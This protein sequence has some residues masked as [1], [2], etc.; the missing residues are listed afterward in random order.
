VIFA[1]RKMGW[2]GVDIGTSSVKLVQLMRDQDGVRIAASA[3]VARRDAWPLE[4]LA[5]CEAKSSVDE[6]GVGQSLQSGFR[7]NRV[8]A[9]LPMALSDVHVL[10]TTLDAQGDREGETDRIVRQAIETATQH[11]ADPLLCDHWTAEP[12]QDVGSPG[13]TNVLTVPTAWSDQLC[14]DISQ[15]GWSCE[16]VDGLPFALARAVTMTQAS[17][18]L[19]A[20][21]DLG[22]GRATLCMIE[23]G[24]PIY[25]RILKQ[26]GLQRML[27][28]L[29]DN[30][31]LSSQEAEQL[32][33]EHGLP[34]AR[35]GKPR[36]EKA[37]LIAEV[38][39]APLAQWEQEIA[40]SLE[41]FQ[42]QRRRG[43]PIRLCLFGGGASVK[44][45]DKHLAHCLDI[46]VDVW[47]LQKNL[48]SEQPPAIAESLL[49][50]AIALSALAWEAS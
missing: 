3:V 1:S 50:P 45:L 17:S 24:Q 7:G 28:A 29:S 30:L 4:N 41:H 36:D 25:V 18:G 14:Q 15:A 8:A 49:G 35:D 38:I 33:Q 2:I 31:N 5:E 47:R 48:S 11:S 13:R 42:A 20:A 6:L 23:E 12:A 37:Q 26:C 22:F 40:R 39:A 43:D 19:V 9:S 44:H 16:L 10:Q 27:S 32:L 46:Q 21:L 34:A